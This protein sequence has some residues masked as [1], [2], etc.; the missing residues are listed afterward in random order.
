M[1]NYKALQRKIKSMSARQIILAMVRGLETRHTKIDMASYG[2]I[3]E[4]GVCYGCAAT[5]TICELRNGWLTK[6]NAVTV[7]N[8]SSEGDAAKCFIVSFEHAINY[9]RMTYIGE[10]NIIAAYAGFA[11]IVDDIGLEG[12][13]EAL[14][15]DDYTNEQLDLYRILAFSQPNKHSVK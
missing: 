6:E 1:E 3:N 9:L 13:D 11:Q 15:G 8:K 12:Y 14:L 4:G 7:Y 2:F 10:Y 5:N